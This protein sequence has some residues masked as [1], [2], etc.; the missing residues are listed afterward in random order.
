MNEDEKI[1]S[2]PDLLRA[3]R[4]VQLVNLITLYRIV[5]FPIIVL[6]IFLGQVQ[7]FKWLLVVSFITDAMDGFIARRYKA[8]SVLGARLDS[9][10]DD[11]TIVA[12]LIGLLM[13][14]TAFM[15]EEILLFSVPFVLF[16]AQFLA[17]LIRYGKMTSFH[18]YLAKIA[19]VL[20]GFFLCS[21]FFIDKPVYWLFYLTSFVTIIELAEEIIIVIVLSEW[22][23][24][25][26]GLYWLTRK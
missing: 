16:I 18:T 26:K 6:F 5:T 25:V 23:T 13:E 10:G 1:K 21:M 9:I 19:A 2:L 17:S 14:K 12:A 7:V 22:Q 11:L 4:P 8:N 20:Q 15:K 24:N 3:R